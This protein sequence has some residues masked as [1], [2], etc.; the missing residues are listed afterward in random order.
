LAAYVVVDID[1][2]DLAAFAEYQQLAGPLVAKYGGK[3]LAA[4][5]PAA[6]LEGSWQPKGI[7][8]LEFPTVEQAQQWHAAPEY[9]EPKALRQ[10]AAT[11]HA[12]LVAG[13]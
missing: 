1:I 8:I 5:P 12:I 11:C 7:T 3:L 9:Q 2:T 13:H 4:G 6:T 10:R